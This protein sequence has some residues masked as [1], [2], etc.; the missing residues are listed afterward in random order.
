MSYDFFAERDA[1]EKL[2]FPQDYQ[3]AVYSPDGNMNQNLRN[4]L[5]QKEIQRTQFRGNRRTISQEDAKNEAKQRF[6]NKNEL[7][8]PKTNSQCW[9]S[10]ESDVLPN[11]SSC[12]ILA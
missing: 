9:L 7:R 10:A 1:A 4:E 3:L 12:G 8:E 11:E 2:M 6:L 5:D